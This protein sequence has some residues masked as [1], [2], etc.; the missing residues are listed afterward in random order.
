VE[1]DFQLDL[2]VEN[3]SHTQ[4]VKRIPPGSR[5]L[6]LG[7]ATGY[8]SDYLRRELDCYVVG[9]EYDR[10]MANKAKL[11]CDQVIVADVQKGNW[12]KKIEGERFDIITCADILEHLRDPISLLKTL[13]DLLVEGGRLLASVPNGGHAALR[14]ELLEGSFTYEDTGLLD[15]T[16]LHL[17]TYHSLRE[18]FARGGF[19]VKELAY[20]FHDMAD[21]VIKSRLSRLGLDVTDQ[22]L[23]LFHTPDAAAY[24]FIVSAAADP[25]VD[26]D[27][28][29]QLSDKPLQS[30]TEVYRVLHDEL[31]NFRLSSAQQEAMIKER[32]RLLR[33]QHERVT[34]LQRDL[35]GTSAHVESLRTTLEQVQQTYQETKAKHDELS[36]SLMY[37]LKERDQ[38]ERELETVH[39]H[40][41]HLVEQ[42]QRTKKDLRDVLN[43]RG[44]RG[45][46]ALTLPLRFFRSKQPTLKKWL[47]DPSLIYTWLRS[48]R[49]P[50]DTVVSDAASNSAQDSY[51]KWI[52]EVEAKDQPSE[53]V[54][55]LLNERND[56]PLISIIMPVYNVEERWLRASINSVL[57]QS[58]D[59]WELCIADDASTKPHIK[60]VLEEYLF[61]YKRIK[62]AYRDENGHISAATN[63]ALSMAAGDFVG[64]MD[65][66]DVLAPHALY[67]V[68]SELYFNPELGLV[69]TD[70]DKIDEDGTRFD[71]YFKAD[72]NPDLMRSHNMICH[73]GVYRRSLIERIGGIREG[74]E[75]AQDYD[76]ALRCLRE[77]DVQKEVRHLPKVL[78]HWRAIPEST[79]SG[80]DVKAYAIDAAI[81]AVEDDLR[82]RGVVADVSESDLI[83]GMIRVRYPLPESPPLVSIIIPT[84]NGEALLRQCVDSIRSKTDYQHYEIVVVDN[85]SDEQRT[86]DYLRELDEISN[87]TVVK[88]D[89]P[90]NFSAINNFAV[91]HANGEVLCFVNDDIEVIDNGWLG[92]M[93][94]HASRPEIGA[95]GAR[96][97]YPD[98]RLQHGGVVLGIGGVAGHAMKYAAKDDIGYMGRAMIIQNYTAVTAAC[99]LLRREVFDEVAGFDSENL[100]VAFNDVDL[101][102]RIFQKGYYNLWTPYAAL[103]HH[104]SASRGAEDTVEKQQRFSKEA[105]YM[106]DKYGPLLINDPAYN[107]N[108]TN[109]REDFS[110][111]W[112]NIT[113]E[114][115]L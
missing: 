3:N 113:V 93:V 13:P 40:E 10:K 24:Q 90:F 72:F 46:M 111:N 64:F 115:D 50:T 20:T 68:A 28:F 85:Q 77:L 58:Y 19:S 108:L 92:E 34:Q 91:D 21:P 27:A 89:K 102:I 37:E 101:C 65:H 109:K 7:C 4:I 107:P 84:R 8:M 32:D 82:A 75:G 17:F 31:H 15:R 63:T 23:A 48:L 39:E 57:D 103:Y 88:Y 99:M 12:Q 95:V 79:A 6:E 74:Y 30:S 71:H 56:R 33:E 43:S 86:L 1:Y 106:L 14:L 2:S 67:H 97:L 52:D 55:R 110:L 61:R 87:I 5:V 76:L 98:D 42:L 69:Y 26:I 80:C 45:Y 47:K 105:K 36:F 44:W 83:A 49:Q 66:D 54:I 35:A 25:E 104:E 22:G 51:T 62:V 81:R 94:S 114:H 78:Y 53:K 100:A 60:Q 73:F 96:L 38:L 18:I 16:H 11:V 9:V 70:E 59:N 41:K 29:P 112:N